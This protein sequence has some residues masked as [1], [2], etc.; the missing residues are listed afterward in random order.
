MTEVAR[1][2]TRLSALDVYV[3]SLL[4]QKGINTAIVEA[5]SFTS[6]HQKTHCKFFT[7]KLTTHKNKVGYK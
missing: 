7:N 4:F 5:F 2:I 3:V 1:S 6:I